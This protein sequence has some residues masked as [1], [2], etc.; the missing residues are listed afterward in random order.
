ML[1]EQDNELLTRVG[2]GT[3]GGELFRRYWQPILP[4]ES[5]DANPVASIRILGENLT[6]FRDRRGS[7]G[8]VDELCPHRRTRLSLGI[9]ELNG[10]RCC[11]HGWLFD[12]EGNCLEMP[13]EPAGSPLKC[14]VKIKAYTVQEMGGLVWAYLGPEPVPVLPKWDL[15]VRPGG[16]RQIIG[17][18]IPTNWLQVAENQADPGHIPY[19]HGRFFQYALERS[20]RR[21]EDPRTFYNSSYAAAAALVEQGLHVQFRPLYNEFG[22]TVGRKLSDQPDDIASW[23]QGTGATIFPAM[24]SSGP[25]DVGKR[26][27]RW[28]QVVVPIDDCHTWQFQYFSYFFPEGVAVPPQAQVPYSEIPLHDADGT[29]ILDYALGQDIAIFQGQGPIAD[30]SRERL[31]TNDVIV[32]ALRN[33]LR[34]QIGEVAAGRDPV[35]VFRDVETAESPDLRIPGAE[36]HL[37]ARNASSMILEGFHQRA[38]GGRLLIDDVVDRYNR[39]RDL[40]VEMYEQSE[41]VMAQAARQPQGRPRLP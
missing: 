26:V 22:Y 6:L 28:Y 21:S 33:L 23:H 30:R 32:V 36:T 8:L 14:K 15:F 39:D 9:P 35:N 41:A 37:P 18:R 40:I 29:D 20:G 31:G 27:R 38:E 16:F 17:H 24:L 34:K 12:S 3:P 13:L 11:Y 2:P 4:A 25:G 7:L 10:L 19:G 1:S 5:L